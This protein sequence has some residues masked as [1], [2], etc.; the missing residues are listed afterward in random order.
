MKT[1]LPG[2]FKL[3]VLYRNQGNADP[4]LIVTALTAMRK[5]SE[6]LFGEDWKVVTDD[7]AV[8]DKATALGVTWLSTEN[9]VAKIA[10]T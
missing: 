10:Q 3:V 7:G 8:P 6:T 4:I 1:E 2:D 5:V 9:L